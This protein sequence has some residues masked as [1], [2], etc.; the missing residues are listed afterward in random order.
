[1]TVHPNLLLA[2]AVLTAHLAVIVF[3]VAGLVVIPLGGWLGWRFVRMRWW[4]LPHLVSMAIVA[5]QALAGRACFLTILEGR[6]AGAGAARGPLI[7]R[8]INRV[9]FWPLPLWAFAALYVVVLLYVVLL[10]RLVPVER[11]PP[12]HGA[13]SH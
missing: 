6:L 3:N 11:R 8:V 13:R 4:R 5:L 12:A 9:I 2:N 10:L 7:M 1:M